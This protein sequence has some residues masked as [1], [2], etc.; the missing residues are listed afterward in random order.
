MV[1]QTLHLYA[2]VDVHKDRTLC[3]SKIKEIFIF[4][5]PYLPSQQ[6]LA[7]FYK[8]LPFS[9]ST[10]HLECLVQSSLMTAQ[11][12]S[13]R[14]VMEHDAVDES[15]SIHKAGKLEPIRLGDEM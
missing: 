6:Q 9:F 7:I 13:N 8:L 12:C 1:H 11:F 10:Q 4:T 14:I 2:F 3:V 15:L 5:C